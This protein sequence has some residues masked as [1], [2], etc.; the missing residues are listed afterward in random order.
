MLELVTGETLPF[1]DLVVATGAN[2]RRPGVD[3]EDD[4]ANILAAGGLEL[5]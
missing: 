3:G 4:L 5:H 1:D 2:C